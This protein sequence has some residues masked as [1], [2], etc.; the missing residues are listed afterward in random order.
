MIDNRENGIG[1]STIITELGGK[2][3][4]EKDYINFPGVGFPR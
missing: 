4:H 1:S 3:G 2:A